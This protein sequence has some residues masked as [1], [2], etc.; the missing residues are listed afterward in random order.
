V[1]NQSRLLAQFHQ[2]F[3]DR[4]IRKFLMLNR[5]YRSSFLAI[6]KFSSL[7]GN[8]ANWQVRLAHTPQWQ[9]SPRDRQPRAAHARQTHREEQ[10]HHDGGH[11]ARSPRPHH[12]AA[13][14]E[15]EGAHASAEEE[16][17]ISSQR[18]TPQIYEG[19]IHFEKLTSQGCSPM[20]HVIMQ[21]IRRQ[22]IVYPTFSE[23]PAFDP[24][25]SLAD[26]V[27]QKI[28]SVRVRPA[29]TRALVA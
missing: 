2:V 22:L 3:P 18:L 20:S 7:F 16:D 17:S 5:A 4:A 19:L 28:K 15:A 8:L 10:R 27:E 9:D 29:K 6:Y 23:C 24:K 21:I 12:P 14:A 1:P 11:G 25:A 26:W 13:D